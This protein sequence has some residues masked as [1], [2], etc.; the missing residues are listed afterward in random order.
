MGLDQPRTTLPWHDHR[1]RGQRPRANRNPY[2]ETELLKGTLFMI[3]MRYGGVLNIIIWILRG[4]HMNMAHQAT[5]V[6]L[7][8]KTRNSPITGSVCFSHV[9]YICALA[10]AGLD[11][12]GALPYI[13]IAPPCM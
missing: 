10:C 2:L 5:N 9:L 12:L 11:S 8:E 7:Y 6:H 13:G 3:F 1:I 4:F